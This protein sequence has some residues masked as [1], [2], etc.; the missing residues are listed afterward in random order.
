[1]LGD[2]APVVKAKAVSVSEEG[3]G[4][5]M[6]EFVQTDMKKGVTLSG[7]EAPVNLVMYYLEY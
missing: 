4:N 1:M 6:N 7:S 5:N 2:E 3:R